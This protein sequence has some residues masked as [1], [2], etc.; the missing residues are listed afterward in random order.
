LINEVRIEILSIS[1][2]MDVG[3]GSLTERPDRFFG[4]RQ[5]NEK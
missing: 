5:S 2:R 4:M 1:V 3:F